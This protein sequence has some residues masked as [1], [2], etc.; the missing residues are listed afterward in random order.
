MNTE[1][2]N[3]GGNTLLPTGLGAVDQV[4]AGIL[5]SITD[6]FFGLDHAWCFTYLNSK[7]EHLLLRT[8]TELLGKS[9]WEEFPQA[10]GSTFEREYRRAAQERITVSFEEFYPPLNTWFEV[11]AYPSAEGISVFFRDINARRQIE[12]EGRGA[13]DAL[14]KSQEDLQLA[15]SAAQLG[16]FYCEW[17]LDKIIWNDTCMEHFFLAPDTEVDFSLFYSLLHPDDREPTRSAIERAMAERVEYNVEYRT[18]AADGRTRWINAIGR[19]YYD[20]AGAPIRF[21]GVTVDIS[22]RK[23]LERELADA[24][25]REALVNQIGQAI[26][27]AQDADSILETAVEALGRALGADRCYYVTYDLPHDLGTLGPDWHGDGLESIAGEYRPSSFGGNQDAQYR[28]GA[29]QIVEDVHAVDRE[30]ALM[31]RLQLRSLVRAPLS[32]GAVMTALVVAMAHA[33]RRWTRNE[34]MLVEAIASQTQASL[35]A[36]RQAQ[37]EHR[38]A[39]ALQDALQ[40]PVPRQVPGLLISPYMRP[41]LEEAEVGG[42]FYDV[43]ALDKELYA[44]VIGDV[45]GKG[46]AAAAQLA[47]VRNMLRGVLYQYRAPAQAVTSLNTILTAHDLLIGF[48]TAFIG[49]YDASTGRITYASCGHE[50]GLARRAATGEVERLEPTGL[51]LGVAESASYGEAEITLSPGDTLLLYTDGLSESGPSRLEMLGT[52]GL[53]RLVATLPEG[54]DVDAAARRIVAEANT[55]ASGVFRDDVCVLLARRQ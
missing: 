10:V 28:Q 24:F 46:L 47:T 26:R 21:D 50:P 9:I 5:E 31:D 41:A 8:R 51:P 48:V 30:T 18:L 43:F 32:P 53:T 36:F 44:V 29:T 22:A 52:E 45:S 33:P 7:A 3:T 35:E 12:E 20:D 2:D 49:I 6:A 54:E 34:I 13:A 4:A 42:D 25:Q 14:R 40:P 19:G 16:T 27:S 11:R 37:R 17:P 15:I 55:N 1:S 39:A 23:R 38:I